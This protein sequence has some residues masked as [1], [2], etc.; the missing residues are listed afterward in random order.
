MFH[1]LVYNVTAG[2]NDANVDMVAVPD[3]EFSRRGGASGAGH[4]IFSEPYN[5][6]AW[7]HLGVSVTDARLNVP[8]IN[9]YARAHTWPVGR[10]VTPQSH[11]RLSDWRDYPMS[12]PIN[13]EIAVEESGNLGAA[14]ELET[15]ALW[16]AS[17]EWNMNLPRGRQRM[18]INATAAVARTLTSWSG[19]GNINFAESLRGGWYAVNHVW[20]FDVNLRYFRLLFP[21]LPLIRGR[22]FR[23][24]SLA[25]NAIG[26]IED[27]ITDGFFGLWG[28]FH[29]FEPPQLEVYGD[30]AGASTQVLKM[31]L[32]YM[33]NESA[34]TGYGMTG[35]VA[36]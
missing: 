34:P 26:N 1:L 4:Y 20:C 13:E 23:P 8:S 14:T 36:A 17:P 6:L 29:T 31:D 11:H 15:S 9:Q 19:G 3:A 28:Y 7:A 32:T 16:I 35:I 5:L 2:V 22:K 25:T 27:P 24:G 33:G 10:S 21:R 18:T 12:L 30:A